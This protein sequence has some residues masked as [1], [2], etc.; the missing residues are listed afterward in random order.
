MK[1]ILTILLV[2]LSLS[3][4]PLYLQEDKQKH[5]VGSMAISATATGLARHYGSNKIESFAIGVATALLVGI[6]K[7][8]YDGA[9]HGT[10]DVQDIYA[11]GIGGV[12]G[13]AIS[14]QFTWEF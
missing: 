13:S 6:A 14:A 2:T 10:Q 7:E 8:R 1:T 5:I 4:E 3:A 12:V 9:G 11:D